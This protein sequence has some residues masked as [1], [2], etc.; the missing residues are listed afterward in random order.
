[1]WVIQHYYAG[2]EYASRKIHEKAA[3]FDHL[4]S[5][6]KGRVLGYKI[7]LEKIQYLFIPANYHL[8]NVVIISK[9]GN[10]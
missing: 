3:Q 4:M 7:S 8:I 10:I 6:I 5:L 9:I 1:M 2:N